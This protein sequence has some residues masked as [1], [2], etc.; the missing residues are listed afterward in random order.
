MSRFKT[1]RKYLPFPEAFSIYW[2]LKYKGGK[3]FQLKKL[4][5]RFSIRDNPYDFATFEEVLL[6]EEYAV[7]LDFTP[8]TIV[9]AGANI[10][11]TSLFFT[12]RYPNAKIISLE[13]D[14]DNFN[15]LK[16]NTASYKNI[17]PV[18]CGLWDRDVFLEIIDEGNGNNAFTVKETGATTAGA[19]KAISIPAIMRE[20]NWQRI[21]ILKMDIEG[22]EKKVFEKG[23]EE[24]LPKIKVLIVELHDRMVQ[25]SSS[26]VFKAVNQ[27]DF[28]MDIKGENLV[29]TN[30]AL[31]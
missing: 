14:T 1:L 16:T 12:N 18:K 28:S 21:D 25:G 10:G 5:D 2:K 19:I 13:P 9:D 17:T 23:Y 30:N 27:Y 4:R 24:W 26:A 29:F 31:K 6:R 20:Q 15:L 7:K 3:D 22:S 8:A 11:L